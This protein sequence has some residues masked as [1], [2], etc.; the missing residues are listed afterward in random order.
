M[1]TLKI[2]NASSR[3]IAY[4]TIGEI[5]SE[6]EDLRSACVFPKKVKSVHN[7]LN[8]IPHLKHRPE[9]I[10]NL[11]LL[12]Y[13]DE[14]AKKLVSIKSQLTYAFK[15]SP[16]Y[17]QTYQMVKDINAELTKSV[18]DIL[19]ITHRYCWA[20]VAPDIKK[21]LTN[22]QKAISTKYKGKFFMLVDTIKYK[23]KDHLAYRFYIRLDNVSDDTGFIYPHY[24]IMLTSFNDDWYINTGAFFR[25]IRFM[26]PGSKIKVSD[27]LAK[28]LMFA[29]Q[30]TL[31]KDGL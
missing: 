2:I 30:Q 19:K 5:I 6:L 24:Y 10:E 26:D 23:S 13:Y 31:N 28:S 15:D 21:D 9:I 25:L 8:S 11:N 29:I 12:H 1:R 17:R 3:Q 18:A 22:I 4:R 14:Q 20:N 7:G 16:D 27:N